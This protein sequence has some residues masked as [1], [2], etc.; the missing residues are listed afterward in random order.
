MLRSS[1][2]TSAASAVLYKHKALLDTSRA[3]QYAGSTM[4]LHVAM[5]ESV[6]TEELDNDASARTQAILG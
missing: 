5:L 6:H 3:V 1:C 2:F 4:A